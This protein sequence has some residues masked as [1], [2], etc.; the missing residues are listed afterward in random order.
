MF[1]VGPRIAAFTAGMSGQ[2]PESQRHCRL[3]SLR[4][5]LVE[6]AIAIVAVSGVVFAN[7]MA[8]PLYG[9]AN[10]SI[11]QDSSSPAVAPKPLLASTAAWL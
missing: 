10:L 11:Q 4:R 1:G 5:L 9:A 2:V 8:D 6:E 7:L 3:G